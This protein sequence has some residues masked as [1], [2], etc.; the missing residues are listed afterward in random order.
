MTPGLTRTAVPTK[1]SQ[2]S[3]YLE[4]MVF[5]PVYEISMT[6]PFVTFSNSLSRLAS[7]STY[8]TFR[9]IP[10]VKYF[11]HPHTSKTRIL[12]IRAYL[13]YSH[14]LPAENRQHKTSPEVSM[15]AEFEK[16]ALLCHHK[17]FKISKQLGSFV[18]FVGVFDVKQR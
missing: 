9:E 12:I 8:N 2:N 13:L 1:S 17:E 4:Q 5:E 7:K 6:V 15:A 3:F 18:Y 10:L 11:L 16:R 14:R